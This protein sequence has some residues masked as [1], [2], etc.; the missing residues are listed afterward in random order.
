M[1]PRRCHSLQFVTTH[2]PQSLF[3]CTLSR[4]GPPLL[5]RPASGKPLSL[6]ASADSEMCGLVLLHPV[7]ERKVPG[8]PHEIVDIKLRKE[9]FSSC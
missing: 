4:K 1:G 6:S 5:S 9:T 7:L 3:K 8:T 2:C